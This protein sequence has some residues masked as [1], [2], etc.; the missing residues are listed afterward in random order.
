MDPHTGRQ[1]CSILNS[2]L[3]SVILTNFY[4]ASSIALK[5]PASITTH[6]LSKLEF[7]L[8]VFTD[9]LTLY[10]FAAAWRHTFANESTI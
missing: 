9:A 2:A 8:K 5:L 4:K 6:V 7:L 1:G 3:I 10:V